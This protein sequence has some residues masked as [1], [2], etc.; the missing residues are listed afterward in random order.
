MLYIL[1]TFVN[2]KV[3]IRGFQ[4]YSITGLLHFARKD[5]WRLCRHCEECS[6]DAIS[7]NLTF[8]IGS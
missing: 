2:K 7:I 1:K 4:K 6:D 8:A 5:K 3:N